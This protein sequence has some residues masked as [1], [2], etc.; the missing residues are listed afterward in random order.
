MRQA[1]F[2]REH[3][4]TSA[5]GYPFARSLSRTALVEFIGSS[6]KSSTA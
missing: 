4:V 5:Q 6:V 3:A 1:E 2:F